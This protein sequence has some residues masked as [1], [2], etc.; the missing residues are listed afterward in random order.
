MWLQRADDCHRQDSDDGNGDDVDDDYGAS[1]Q[2]IES[3]AA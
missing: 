3:A 2:L 1:V